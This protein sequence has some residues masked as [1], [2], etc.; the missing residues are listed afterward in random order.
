MNAADNLSTGIVTRLEGRFAWIEVH[1]EES[2]GSC[3]SQGGC[4]SGLLGLGAR[5]RQYRLANDIGVKPGDAVT[6]AMAGGGVLR[7]ALLAYLLPLVLG[8]GGAAGGAWLGGGDGPALA[9]L[10]AGLAAG[11]LLLRGVSHPRSPLELTPRIMIQSQVIRLQ[12]RLHE[13]S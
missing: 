8:I 10:G 4:G 1:A 9:G 3:K 7:A 12:P 11:L 5:P 2:C 13:E 6:I